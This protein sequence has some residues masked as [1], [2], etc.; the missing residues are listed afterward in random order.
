MASKVY[1]ISLPEDIASFLD[2]D[3][4]LSLSKICQVALR[5][6]IE[7]REVDP[8]MARLK[9]QNAKLAELLEEAQKINGTQ[10]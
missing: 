2:N 6:I 1:S 8:L 4:D 5:R 3:P 7:D 10:G 9:R